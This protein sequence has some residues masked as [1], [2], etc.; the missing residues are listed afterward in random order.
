MS[1]LK[2]RNLGKAFYSYKSEWMRFARWFGFKTKT[3]SETWILKDISFDIHKGEA[4]GIIG[5]NGAGKSTLLKLIT[6]TL[7]PTEGSIHIDGRI[8]ALLE[9]GMGFNPD[10]TGR[11]NVIHSAGMM[12]IT[13]EQIMQKMDEIEA[14]AEIGEYFDQPVRTYSSGMQVRVAFGVATAFRPE[15]LIVDEALSVGDTYFQHKSFDR[16]RQF[17][18]EGTTLLIVSHDKAAIQS[19]C[20]RAILLNAGQIALDGDP[21][22]VFDYYNAMIADKEARKIVVKDSEFG[23]K[24]TS[25][26]SGEVEVTGVKLFNSYGEE[27]DVIKVGEPVSIS[28]TVK[29]SQDVDECVIGVGVKD[30]L[31]QMMFGTNTYHTKQVLKDLKCGDKYEFTV[32]FDANLGVGSYSVVV[33]LHQSETH[34][35]KNFNWIDRAL[36]FE[37]I[38]ADKYV[39]VGCCWNEMKFAISCDRREQNNE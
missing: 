18:K 33:S 26:G 22:E 25:S 12:G 30:R 20:D 1:L 4:I 6:G 9:L 32:S 2:V 7:T 23:K 36:I 5:M 31:G 35:V 27:V 17:Q 14:F 37:V 21:E 38:N 34:I 3:S 19:L 28:I 10:L 13:T 8:S 15:I 29:V 24:Q 16:I 39:F 11:S